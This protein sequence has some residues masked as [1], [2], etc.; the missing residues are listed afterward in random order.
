MFFDHCFSHK[1]WSRKSVQLTR[2]GS[3]AILN[4]VTTTV[5][6]ILSS[7]AAKKCG[8]LPKMCGALSIR[9]LKSGNQPNIPL[10][11]PIPNLPD[12][13][14]PSSLPPLGGSHF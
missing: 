2:K 8:P 4:M 10:S 5:K 14:N 9:D 12:S 6:S 3:Q 1:E 7:R 13:Q 11:T